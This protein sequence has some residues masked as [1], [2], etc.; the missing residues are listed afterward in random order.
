MHGCD[1]DH[2]RTVSS[3][4]KVFLSFS[5]T[6]YL[7]VLSRLP[8]IF[9]PICLKYDLLRITVLEMHSIDQ[10]FRE[11]LYWCYMNSIIGKNAQTLTNK[12]HGKSVHEKIATLS[13]DKNLRRV[14]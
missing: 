9:V 12:N 6:V 4:G 8:E 3:I 13:S 11:G 5:L 14:S 2:P 7:S 10:A 1:L